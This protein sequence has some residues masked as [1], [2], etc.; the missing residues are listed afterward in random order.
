MYVLIY[1]YMYAYACIQ[2][3]V[4]KYIYLCIIRVRFAYLLSCT[5]DILNT[6]IYFYVCVCLC[7]CAYIYNVAIEDK[8]ILKQ[9]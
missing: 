9:N 8:R 4:C 6:A 5:S 2:V 1:A 7:G 3:Y